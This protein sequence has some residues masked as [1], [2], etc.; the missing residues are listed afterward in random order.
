VTAPA[1]WISEAE[2][3]AHLDGELDAARSAAVDAFLAAHPEEAERARS[4]RRQTRLIA[5]A[6]GPLLERPLPAALA[7][8][9]LAPAKPAGVRWRRLAMA[10]AVALLLFAGGAGSGWW[11][12]ERSTLPPPEAGLVADAVSAHLIYTAEVRHPVEVGADEQDHLVTWLSR[13]LGLPLAAPNLAGAGFE[14]VGGR[15]LPAAHG[16]AA[17]LMYQDASGR[18]LT[19]YVRPSDDPAVET[20]FRFT[21]QG[22]VTALYWRD[23]GGAWA[24]LGE[25]PREELLQLAHQVYQ[26]LQG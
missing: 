15:L 8:S 7:A 17:Q 21:R 22:P 16:P 3:Q 9:L 5:R 14:L 20:A 4:L 11:L 12:R 19:L 1:P 18:R 10:A 2:L 23:R 24:L 6:Y 26:A 25:L 13:R